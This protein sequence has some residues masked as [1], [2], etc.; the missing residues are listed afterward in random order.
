MTVYNLTLPLTNEDVE[1]LNIG[2]VVYLCGVVCTARDMAHLKMRELVVHG[3]PLPENLSGGAIFHAG[4]IMV[5]DGQDHWKLHVIGPTTSIRMEPH[6]DF[7]GQLGVKL[8]IGKGGMGSDSVV[9]FRKYRQVYLQ[10]IPGCAVA[11]ASG[12]KEVKDVHWLENGMPE[13]MWVMET[14]HFGPFVVMMDCKGNS[15]YEQVKQ[16]A[17]E[18]MRNITEDK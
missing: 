1:R 4:P 18:A 5:K 14:A 3:E 17:Y 16:Q 15:H 9:A 2:D 11:L 6:A 12:V 13:A 7:V 10:A 8:V